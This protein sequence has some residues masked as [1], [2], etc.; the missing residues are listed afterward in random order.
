MYR[1]RIVQLG[2]LILLGI[3]LLLARLA[4][5]QLIETK[6]FTKRD[7]N[8]IEASVEQRTQTLILDHGRGKFYDR[9]GKP[10]NYETIPGLVLFPF[11]KN[12]NWNS[13]KVAE[14]IGVEEEELLEAVQ[15]AKDPFIFGG[16]DP[17][18]LTEE[19]MD[20]INEL[21]IP[22]VFAVEQQLDKE[23]PP[24]IH[25]IGLIGENLEEAKR[26]YPEK[27]LPH[28]VQI[29]IT[30]LQKSFDEFLLQEEVSKLVFHVDGKGGPLFGIDVKY[31]NPSNPFYPI[32]VNTTIDLDIQ[33]KAEEIVDT[34]GLKKGGLVLLDIKTNSVLAMVSRP[35][36]DGKDPFKDDGAKNFMTTASIPGSI[37]K[38]V[39]AAAAIDYNLAPPT[40]TFDCSQNIRGEEDEIFDHGVYN[41]TTSFAAS[42]NYTF[43]T[44]A[45]ELSQIDV[46]L[47]ETYAEKMGLIQQVGWHGDVFHYKDF[48][49]IPDEEKGQ[50]FLEDEERIDSNFVAQTGIGQ[51]NVRV[52]P[53]QVANLMATIAKGG[54]KDMVRAV[55]SLEYKNGTPLYRFINSELDGEILAP[56]TTMKLQHLLREVVTNPKGTGQALNNLPYAVAGKSGT[57]ETGIIDEQSGKERLNRWFAGYFP[58]EEP[59]Y[60]LVVVDLEGIKSPSPITIFQDMVK[61]L[62][63]YDHQEL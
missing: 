50:V 47:I 36:V 10:I 39:I 52:T 21:E 7:I 53:L 14:I 29:G 51:K 26:R 16:E 9:N 1:R 49:Q 42:C 32:K 59:K 11:L 60:A 28:D 27:I 13:E 54:K 46:N 22:G 15:E 25:L 48:K 38:T 24:A 6:T 56:Y 2:C 23:V 63:N 44:L 17:F 35:M 4:Q 43:G 19:Q 3:T 12:M 41:F 55:S 45:K 33:K 58:F 57:A 37:F 30:G 20:A 61:F 5:I 18:H 62:Y 40:R 8:L 34:L 31:V